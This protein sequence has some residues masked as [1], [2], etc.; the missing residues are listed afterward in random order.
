MVLIGITIGNM[1]DEPREEIAATPESPDPGEP[2]MQAIGEAD[3]GPPDMQMIA[4][5]AARS[6][7]EVTLIIKESKDSE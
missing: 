6:R 5:S 2:V 1:S 7:D 4:G 3:P